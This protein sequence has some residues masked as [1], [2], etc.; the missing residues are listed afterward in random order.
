MNRKKFNTIIVLVVLA[1]S[2]LALELT[3]F[4]QSKTSFK[5]TGNVKTSSRI[6]YHGG[7]VVTST[8]DA[9]FIWYGCWDSTCGTAGDPV[10][11][12][13]VEDFTSSIGGS[14][15]LQILSTYPDCCGHGPTGALLFA[16]SVYDHY[17]RGTDLTATDIAGII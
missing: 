17:S 4:G 9:Y 2:F 8:V 3:A 1:V 14:P 6:E 7:P 12:T 16:G 15:Y 11:K 10:T 5:T 13:L